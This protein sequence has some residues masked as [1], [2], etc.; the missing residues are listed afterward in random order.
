MQI[1][2]VDLNLAMTRPQDIAIQK[3]NEDNKGNL[4]HAI[5]QNTVDRK[6][7]EKATTVKGADN[8]HAKETGIG[9]VLR[10]VDV[11]NRLLRENRLGS[12][13]DQNK[14]G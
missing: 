4:D 11:F 1:G 10:G 2:A 5:L 13:S 3:Q 8:V 7:E 14:E 6:T 12:S 9:R